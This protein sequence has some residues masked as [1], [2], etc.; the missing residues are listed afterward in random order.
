MI[1]GK[2]EPIGGAPPI[3]FNADIIKHAKMLGSAS[4]KID[5]VVGPSSVCYG[6]SVKGV[7]KNRDV[8]VRTI[9]DHV[10]IVVHIVNSEHEGLV[11]LVILKGGY[12]GGRRRGADD[13]LH[14]A[15]HSL[16]FEDNCQPLQEDCADGDED[17]DGDDDAALVAVVVSLVDPPEVGVGEEVEDV[18][19]V[20]HGYIYMI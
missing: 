16:F 3:E 13:G 8:E 1:E 10:R 17:E 20:K 11:F 4:F 15:D 14:G 6:G 18:Q 19:D 5:G 9:E 7:D 12:G 2:A